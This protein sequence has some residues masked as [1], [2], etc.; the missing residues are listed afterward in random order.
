MV[1]D[2]LYGDMEEINYWIFNNFPEIATH[3][4][5][6]SCDPNLCKPKK[7]YKE[8]LYKKRVEEL[9]EEDITVVNHSLLAKW[10]YKDEKPIENLIV[11]E[12]HN[13]VEKGYEFFASEVEYRALKFFLQEIYPAEL[14]NNSPFAYTSRNKKII[15]PFDRFY[16]FIKLDA[17]NK[18][19]ISR[20]INLIMEEA[21]YILQYGKMNNY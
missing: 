17:N 20:E 8:C 1:K 16:Y 10:P 15:K 14:I 13:L 18:A 4:R 12:A 7:C 3:L 2:G 11:D 9:K 19:K 5:H 6:V 21:E